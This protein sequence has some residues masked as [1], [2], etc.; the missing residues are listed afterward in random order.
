MA[1]EKHIKDIYWIILAW[2]FALAL[3][4][5]VFLKAKLFFHW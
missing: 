1:K 5:I 4:Y 2:L 3:L